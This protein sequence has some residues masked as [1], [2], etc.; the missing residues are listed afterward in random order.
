MNG[1][2]GMFQPFRDP[3]PS[4]WATATNHKINSA[5]IEPRDD[6]PYYELGCQWMDVRDILQELPMFHKEKNIVSRRCSLPIHWER[7]IMILRNHQ[8]C[9]VGCRWK[10]PV[11][12]TRLFSSNQ[13]TVDQMY[14]QNH[15]PNNQFCIYMYIIYRY[16]YI[17]AP[18]RNSPTWVVWKCGTTPRL[19][20]WSMPF[21]LLTGD[22]G[23]AKL[24]SYIPLSQYIELYPCY[25]CLYTY[26]LSGWWF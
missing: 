10:P 11:S 3:F 2:G 14:Y 5:H 12:N 15:H 1:K 6:P 19:D 18:S 16:I 21:S 8:F 20:G 7:R 4:P 24:V 26:L 9:I 17:F 13:I 22:I 25:A 23:G